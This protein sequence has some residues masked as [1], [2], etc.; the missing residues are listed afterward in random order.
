M[1]SGSW[2]RDNSVGRG[3]RRDTTGT[4]ILRFHLS[5]EFDERRGEILVWSDDR[6]KRAFV[7]VSQAA[8]LLLLRKLDHAK[9]WVNKATKSVDPFLREITEE[10]LPPIPRGFDICPHCNGSGADFYGNPCEPCDAQG[11][12]N[13]DI[14]IMYEEAL[15]A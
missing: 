5:I 15:D 7:P 10:E 2:V 12:V 3:Q 9:Q 4:S 8:Q 13:E 11:L 6:T 14:V 1:Q